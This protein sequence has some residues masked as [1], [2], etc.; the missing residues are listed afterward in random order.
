MLVVAFARNAPSRIAEA[1]NWLQT[2]MPGPLLTRCRGRAT[3]SSLGQSRPR[4]RSL[5]KTHSPTPLGPFGCGRNRS[6]RRARWRCCLKAPPSGFTA[7]PKAGAAS[8][9]RGSPAICSKSFSAPKRLKQRRHR[10]APTSIPRENGPRRPPGLRMASRPQGLQPTAGTGHSVSAARAK[11]A[12][13]IM[14]AWPSGCGS[15][16]R[17]LPYGAAAARERTSRI[18]GVLAGSGSWRPRLVNQSLKPRIRSK[19][20]QVRR[21]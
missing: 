19:R 3:F 17:V 21:A 13:R 6:R 5:L 2:E 8:R 9:C 20:V 10:G 12:A 4:P 15:R 7:A 16:S 11:G 14:A 1:V 18:R